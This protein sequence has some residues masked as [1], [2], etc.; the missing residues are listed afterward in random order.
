MPQKFKIVNINVELIYMLMHQL[1]NKRK[2]YI[3]L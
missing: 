3:K 1:L 2:D